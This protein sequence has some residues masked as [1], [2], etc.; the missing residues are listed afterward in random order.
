MNKSVYL[1][2]AR[3]RSDKTLHNLLDVSN[4]ALKDMYMLKIMSRC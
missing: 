1:P 4:R 3:Q 2:K